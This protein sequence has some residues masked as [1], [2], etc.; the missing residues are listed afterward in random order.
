M[1]LMMLIGSLQN[2]LRRNRHR[3][4]SDTPRLLDIA[5]QIC[6]AMKYLESSKFIHRDLAA[7][8]CLVGDNTIVKVADFGL[9]RFVCSSNSS[10]SITC[11]TCTGAAAPVVVVAAAPVV[12][13]AAASVVVVVVYS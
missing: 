7:R 13:A 5:T 1:M 11:N 10:S 8:N 9:A 6:S 12:V 4:L 2:F 3:L